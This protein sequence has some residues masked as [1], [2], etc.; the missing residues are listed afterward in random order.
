MGGEN[1]REI[2]PRAVSPPPP[3]PPHPLLNKVASATPLVLNE[4]LCIA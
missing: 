2:V 4:Y 1:G 3:P